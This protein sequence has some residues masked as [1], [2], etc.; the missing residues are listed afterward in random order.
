MA[1]NKDYIFKKINY[2]FTYGSKAW[3]EEMPKGYYMHKHSIPENSVL[4]HSRNRGVIEIG[5]KLRFNPEKFKKLF[6]WEYLDAIAEIIVDEPNLVFDYTC[7]NNYGSIV[8]NGL[9]Y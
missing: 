8:T 2:F 4:L 9:L 5:P 3:V 1:L 7:K 6:K